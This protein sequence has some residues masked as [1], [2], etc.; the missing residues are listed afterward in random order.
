MIT[1][2][3]VEMSLYH[4]ICKT[5][6]LVGTR[7]YVKCEERSSRGSHLAISRA[8]TVITRGVIARGCTPTFPQ[9]AWWEEE[10]SSMIH[11]KRKAAV[12]TLHESAGVHLADGCS[13]G[14]SFL[15]P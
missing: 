2:L 8:V 10:R 6:I 15:S 11:R 12:Q 13:V 1:G 7:E 4:L 14:A 9:A 5:R 3:L